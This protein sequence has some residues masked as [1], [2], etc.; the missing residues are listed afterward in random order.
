MVACFDE[1][2]M[3]QYC[4]NNYTTLSN[5]MSITLLTSIC[6]NPFLI[7][8]AMYICTTY[9][10]GNIY[11][12]V[13]P[14]VTTSSI[15]VRPLT[16]LLNSFSLFNRRVPQPSASISRMT[17]PSPAQVERELDVGVAREWTAGQ[18]VLLPLGPRPHHVPLPVLAQTVSLDVGRRVRDVH[19]VAA[20]MI[21]SQMNDV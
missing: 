20:Q 4:V 11:K 10:S 18:D 17:R 1:E 7:T 6:T 9:Y 8:I 12:T 3:S 5:N 21:I 2:F 15:R 13:N 14:L 19:P 16:N